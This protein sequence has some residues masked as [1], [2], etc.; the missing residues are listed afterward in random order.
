MRNISVK[1]SVIELFRNG[2]I[3]TRVMNNCRRKGI[4]SVGD[5]LEI[6][7]RY[8][9]LFEKFGP[10]TMTPSLQRVVST[11]YHQQSI[12]EPINNKL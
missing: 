5:I 8:G 7:E 3:N 11:Y 1:T 6:I 10:T 2:M 12:N 4:Y 9:S